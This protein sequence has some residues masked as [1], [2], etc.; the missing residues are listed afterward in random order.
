VNPVRKE[1]EKAKKEI[2][3]KNPQLK[4]KHDPTQIIS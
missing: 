3:T 2:E 4:L 1:A